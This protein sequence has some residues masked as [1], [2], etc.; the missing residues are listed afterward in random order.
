LSIQDVAEMSQ[1]DKDTLEQFDRTISRTSNASLSNPTA[2]QVF[3]TA[4]DGVKSLLAQRN[5]AYGNFSN[6]LPPLLP[7]R[8]SGGAATQIPAFPPTDE[9]SRVHT[10]VVGAKVNNLFTP[11]FLDTL[12]PIA[13]DEA[14]FIPPD[15][16]EDKIFLDSSTYDVNSTRKVMTAISYEFSDKPYFYGTVGGV[17]IGNIRGGLPITVIG[18]HFQPSGFAV[19]RWTDTTSWFTYFASLQYFN[20]THAL[21]LT[22]KIPTAIATVLQISN[23][24]YIFSQPP[25]AETSDEGF[26]FYEIVSRLPLSGSSVGRTGVILRGE[27]LRRVVAVNA[28]CFFSTSDSELARSPTEY[29]PE[30]DVAVCFSPPI[31]EGSLPYIAQQFRILVGYELIFQEVW[32]YVTA[33]GPT[34][35]RAQ[36][37]PTLR[38]IVVQLQASTNLGSYNKSESCAKLFS[39]QS[40]SF[41]RKSTFVYWPQPFTFV[42]LLDPA[43]GVR[44]NSILELSSGGDIVDALDSSL[45]LAGA[46]KF[47]PPDFIMAPTPILSCP[48]HALSANDL[49]VS[50]HH[51]FGLL[52]QNVSFLWNVSISSESGYFSSL[53]F[54]QVEGTVIR[55]ASNAFSALTLPRA[56]TNPMFEVFTQF[57]VFF[58]GSSGNQ[59]VDG[60]NV[61][62][63]VSDPLLKSSSECS[64]F[65][66]V[67][68]AVKSNSST[69]I[70]WSSVSSNCISKILQQETPPQIY[71][72]R[73]FNSTFRVPS[74]SDVTF[75][76]VVTDPSQS[77]ASFFVRWIVSISKSGLIHPQLIPSCAASSNTSNSCDLNAFIS[78]KYD[79]ALSGPSLFLPGNS[80]PAGAYDLTATLSRMSNCSWVTVFQQTSVALP[81]PNDPG[82]GSDPGDQVSPVDGGGMGDSGVVGDG[83]DVVPVKVHQCN[84]T[85]LH[86]DTVKFQVLSVHASPTAFINGAVSSGSPVFVDSG[87]LV[88]I[89]L[90]TVSSCNITAPTAFSE[91]ADPKDPEFEDTRRNFTDTVSKSRQFLS[92][93]AQNVVLFSSAQFIGMWCSRCN[94]TVSPDIISL[95]DSLFGP[96]TSDGG[97]SFPSPSPLPSPS[98]PVELPP[99]DLPPSDSPSSQSQNMPLTG[100]LRHTGVIQVRHTTSSHRF[101]ENSKIRTSAQ[102]TLDDDDPNT[103]FGP[104]VYVPTSDISYTLEQVCVGEFDLNTTHF[105]KN[106]SFFLYATQTLLRKYQ[107]DSDPN[108]FSVQQNVVSVRPTLI[109][110]YFQ[111]YFRVLLKD[112][113]VY[114]TRISPLYTVQWTCVIRPAGEPSS[115][116]HSRNA[117]DT[118]CSNFTA[119]SYHA[120]AIF[121]DKI[122]TSMVARISCNIVSSHVSFFLP[123]Q[124]VM[125]LYPLPQNVALTQQR[126]PVNPTISALNVENVVIQRA[127][128]LRCSNASSP[129]VTFLSD[130]ISSFSYASQVQWESRVPWLNDISSAMQD[131]MFDSG[132]FLLN[133]QIS[134]P[135]PMLSLGFGYVFRVSHFFRGQL[136]GFSEVVVN[137]SAPFFQGKFAVSKLAFGRHRI[138][139]YQIEIDA[140]DRPLQFSFLQL[141]DFDLTLQPMGFSQTYSGLLYDSF[142]PDFNCSVA[143]ITKTASSLTARSIVSVS[144]SA[145]QSYPAPQVSDLQTIL[146][147]YQ[148][149]SAGFYHSA[150][151]ILQTYRMLSITMKVSSALRPSNILNASIVTKGDQFEK[152]LLEPIIQLL[153]LHY[154]HSQESHQLFS[155]MLDLNFTEILGPNSTTKFNFAVPGIQAFEHIATTLFEGF[156]IFANGS[157]VSSESCARII[158]VI[159]PLFE[160][161]L[162]FS[163]SASGAF[164]GIIAQ[165]ADA[166]IQELNELIQRILEQLNPSATSMEDATTNPTTTSSPSLDDTSDASS[167]PAD[168]TYIPSSTSP[169][170][171]DGTSSTAAA[172]DTT[173][174]A[175]TTSPS[176]LEGATSAGSSVLVDTT[177]IPSA[178]LPPSIDGASGTAAPG[179]N[180]DPAS[181]VPPSQSSVS[182]NSS[183]SDTTS[184]PSSAFPPSEMT[185]RNSLAYSPSQ[186]THRQL[187]QANPIFPPEVSS[188]ASIVV[189]KSL[190]DF[191]AVCDRIRF[192]ASKSG[193]PTFFSYPGA[194]VYARNFYTRTAVTYLET[195]QFTY[196]G[197]SCSSVAVKLQSEM[198]QDSKLDFHRSSICVSVS[199]KDLTP[200]SLTVG[201]TIGI[202]KIRY[203]PE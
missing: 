78:R 13:E 33:Q 65:K 80:L 34:I 29:S 92:S 52:L 156:R 31:F 110:Q 173:G 136:S 4:S 182:A 46:I 54:T 192:A 151:M 76:S 152:C 11:N 170:S 166:D 22:P 178:T 98:P 172:A 55:I 53:N 100:N 179:S 68:D 203:T 161:N 72:D 123:V 114:A 134:I 60:R 191:T 49:Y 181:A 84:E 200:T 95:I 9:M 177:Y 50:A 116:Y 144:R 185:N 27:Y 146:S 196:Q 91:S 128:M 135:T 6:I 105:A 10:S 131:A 74:D 75:V 41:I 175:G 164:F 106:C 187:L 48:L 66:S 162:P 132:G 90:D 195:P 104:D 141:L 180:T 193:A 117:Y 163:A 69:C 184:T 119:S 19:A 118:P 190:F 3:N 142:E 77:N 99:P 82:D 93:D 176:S 21:L 89:Q 101:E 113:T 59:P 140:E 63:N 202:T 14:A 26:G 86:S 67:Q 61:S 83:R 143:I 43:A 23:N 149:G 28:T 62:G 153:I 174:N 64:K 96:Q 35:L 165:C 94:G 38:T 1:V 111:A 122:N 32:F 102:T 120:A 18:N 150:Q 199:V 2:K 36:F 188:A 5:S 40:Q 25:A 157:V 85:I 126:I 45:T 70:A 16:L 121:N 51:S 147:Q 148:L 108:G 87:A 194:V 145:L 127:H 112:P 42:L 44:F 88:C 139:T 138:S 97:P 109:C 197:V 24:G 154:H 12:G 189:A 103:G 8:L 39:I 81:P 169:P 57:T 30:L 124:T 168:S 17:S 137:M 155:P 167:T 56:S 160:L 129:Y 58:N 37:D 71:I 158:A 115:G 125:V 159:S 130:P 47:F 186:S 201:G 171:S 133:S 7:Y 15:P 20:K 73:P 107:N 183:F 198:P 79:L